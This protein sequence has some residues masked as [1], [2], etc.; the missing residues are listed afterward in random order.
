MVLLLLAVMVLLV[1]IVVM[2]IVV[3]LQIIPAAIIPKTMTSRMT[4]VIAHTPALGDSIESKHSRQDGIQHLHWINSSTM[5][6]SASES[7]FSKCEVLPSGEPRF[8]RLSLNVAAL[9]TTANTI[10]TNKIHLNICN[11]TLGYS[12]WHLLVKVALDT[13]PTPSVRW[14]QAHSHHQITSH[15]GHVPPEH[16]PQSHRTHPPHHIQLHIC[17]LPSQMCRAV[18]SNTSKQHLSHCSVR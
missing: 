15:Q 13:T 1:V 16:T 9:T 10:T 14:S 7:Q 6:T 8:K 4:Q 12:G 18:Q 3:V 5:K 2:L 17:I 11:D